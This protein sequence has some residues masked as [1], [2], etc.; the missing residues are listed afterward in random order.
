LNDSFHQRID[1][2]VE[3]GNE[4]QPKFG[5]FVLLACGIFPGLL[6]RSS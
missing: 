3:R 1:S 5:H 6:I 2:F 4:T